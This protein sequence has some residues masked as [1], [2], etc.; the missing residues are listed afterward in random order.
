MLLRI[1]LTF[2]L[3]IG[4]SISPLLGQKASKKSTKIDVVQFPTVPT[5]ASFRVSLNLFAADEFFALEDLRRYGGN[6]DLLKSSGERLS[7]MKYF[8]VGQKAVSRGEIARAEAMVLRSAVGLFSYMACHF[9]KRIRY[10]N[11]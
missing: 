5:D 4:L 3:V 8:T 6:M 1:L 2:G 7:G 9:G 11:Y 10:C